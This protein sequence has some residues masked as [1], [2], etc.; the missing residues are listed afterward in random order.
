MVE[1]TQAFEFAASHRLYV[2]SWSDDEN[3]KMFGKCAN[4]NG[5]GHN[6]VVEVTVGGRP[7]EEAGTVTD[8]MHVQRVVKER[9]IEPFDHKHLNLDCADFASLNPTVENV[10]KVIWRRLEGSF[11]RCRLTRVRIWE[12][13]KAYAEYDGRD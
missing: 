6:Y 4:P 1:L 5:H 12:T 3:R 11:E 8:V 7:L 9:V 13:P 2:P 10:A